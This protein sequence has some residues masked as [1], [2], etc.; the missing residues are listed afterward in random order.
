MRP[1]QTPIIVV[2]KQRKM[3]RKNLLILVSCVPL[4][5]TVRV[6]FYLHY[7]SF[8]GI[9][10]NDLFPDPPRKMD[11]TSEETVDDKA[12]LSKVATRGKITK[13]KRKRRRVRPSAKC[14]NKP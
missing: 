4:N 1:L 8:L 5:S 12:D 2:P 3:G 10:M 9:R 11:V 6:T 13:A 14:A 7:G